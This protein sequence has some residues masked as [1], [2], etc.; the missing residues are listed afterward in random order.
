GG[1]AEVRE[2][3]VGG[4]WGGT[5]TAAGSRAAG[6]A[7]V[8]GGSLLCDVRGGAGKAVKEM[9]AGAGSNAVHDVAG[10]GGG[11]AV[12]IQWTGRH[13]GGVADSQS[14]RIAVRGTDRVFREHAGATDEDGGREEIRG[15][16]GGGETDDAGGL[17]ASGYTVRAA[18]GG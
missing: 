10:G 1:G 5:G 18:G 7:D 13:R 16:T 17:R 4:D 15:V 12:A 6:S 11:I 9:D 8:C 3:G 2:G 14:E